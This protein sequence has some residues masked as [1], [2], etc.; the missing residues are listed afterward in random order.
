M[1]LEYTLIN[2]FKEFF[3]KKEKEKVTNIT[4][5]II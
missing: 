3:I 1:L 5:Y 2:Y 4:K